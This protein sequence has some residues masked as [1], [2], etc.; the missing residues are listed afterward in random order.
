M[1]EL[2][3]K[4]AQKL[5]RKIINYEEDERSFFG[6][7]ASFEVRDGS[8]SKFLKGV[9]IVITPLSLAGLGYTAIGH[10]SPA[11]AILASTAGL[12]AGGIAAREVNRIV[13]SDMHDGQDGSFGKFGHWLGT[14]LG[15]SLV[16]GGL[17]V[18][19]NARMNK[20]NEAILVNIPE[21]D[22]LVRSPKAS[23]N[24]IFVLGMGTLAQIGASKGLKSV[25]GGKQNIAIAERAR[26]MVEECKR[27]GIMPG[28]EAP[29]MAEVKK[30][31]DY[32]NS[33]TPEE[34]KIMEAK[35]AEKTVDKS[36]LEKELVEEKDTTVQVA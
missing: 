17:E 9:N 25:F 24:R 8:L 13:Y 29:Q 27:T 21:T 6:K 7:L 14:L 35:M 20:N 32:M 15:G 12:A 18:L 2:K 11:L 5:A 19:T 33:V 26:E 31:N 30:T 10:G 28:S 36:Q 3:E 34:T 4:E 23:L 16:H 1:D 22:R